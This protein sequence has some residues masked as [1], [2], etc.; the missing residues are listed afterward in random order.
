MVKETDD[1]IQGLLA[2]ALKRLAGGEKD[3]DEGAL[4]VK[5]P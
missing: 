3:D 2:W 4:R 1:N 5:L